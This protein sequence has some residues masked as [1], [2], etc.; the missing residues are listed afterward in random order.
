MGASLPSSRGLWRFSGAA[1]LLALAACGTG[2]GQPRQDGQLFGEVYADV[3]RYHIDA[4]DPERLA[5]AALAGL[6]RIDPAFVVSMEKGEVILNDGSD[7]ARERAPAADDAAAWGELTA[8]MLAKARER[9]PLIA[10]E[11]PDIADERVIDA[12]LRT[13]DR[14][15]R[16]VRPEVARDHRDERDGFIGVGVT[17]DFSGGAVRVASVLPET[18]AAAAGVQVADRIV[19]IDGTALAALSEADVEERLLGPKDSTV[20]LEIARADAASPVTLVM[21]RDVIFRETVT[22]E[23]HD[24]IAWLKVTGFNQ[25]TAR[26]AARLLRGAHQQLGPAFRGIVL[27]LRG[28]PGGLLDQAVD[29]ASIFLAAVPVASTTGRVPESQQKFE[30]P[31][32]GE[33]ERAPLVVLIDGGSASSSEIVAAALQDAG[34]A[35]VIGSAS[36]GKG[37]VQTVLRTAN[38]G[39]LT[40]TWAELFSPA[41]YALNHHGVVPTVCSAAPDAA[42]DQLQVARAS[43]DDAGWER[44]RALCPP[45]NGSDADDR[46]AALTLLAD[47]TRYRA[48][49][50]AALARPAEALLPN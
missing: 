40:V 31:R 3:V 9:S 27:D 12:A 10:G 6:R 8:R 28:D 14:F 36:F 13:L 38:G 16:Y 30:A 4:T 21:R 46:R 48:A 19:A 2:S 35:V 11:A 37:T 32:E 18:P 29:L 15:S 5:L 23:T 26:A 20:A 1:L 49:L 33:P 24:G 42:A 39:E 41:G 45:R 22:I 44:L 34:R 7:V 50:I 25:R 17:L 47:P 43:L